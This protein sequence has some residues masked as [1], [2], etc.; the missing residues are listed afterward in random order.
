MHS[1]FKSSIEVARILLGAVVVST[2]TLKQEGP[3]SNSLCG[4]CMYSL[5]LSL[6]LIQ[7][8]PAVQK[9]S[10]I[11]KYSHL[12]TRGRCSITD[13]CKCWN[14]ELRFSHE[15]VGQ[16]SSPRDKH[17][18]STKK[19]HDTHFLVCVTILQ[20]DCFTKKWKK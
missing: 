10:G 4:V 5:F 1:Q 12:A 6:K 9:H 15:S 14:S 2:V 18:V 11:L 16:S 20:N 17:K 13:I 19:W 3:G 8:P 7:L